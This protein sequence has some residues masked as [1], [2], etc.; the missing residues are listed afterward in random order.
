[1]FLWIFVPAAGGLSYAKI[2][3]LDA[4][5]LQAARELAAGCCKRDWGS[6]HEVPLTLS[7]PGRSGYVAAFEVPEWLRRTLDGC[8]RSVAETHGWQ[9]PHDSLLNDGQVC[10]YGPGDFFARHRDDDSLGREGWRRITMVVM[11]S[12]GFEGGAFEAGTD[13]L[14]LDAGE[15]VVFEGALEHSVLPV[16]SGLRVTLVL[17]LFWKQEN[18]CVLLDRDGVVN[19]DVGSP[20]VLRVDQLR[21]IDGVAEAIAD[22][23][24]RGHRVVVVTNQSAIRKGLLSVEGLDDI[25]AEM[26]RQGVE[27]DHV[28]YATGEDR[29]PRLKPA[30]DL[31]LRALDKTGIPSTR[32]VMIGD[33]ETD[34]QAARTARVQPLLVTSSHHGQRAAIKEEATTPTFADLPS[35]LRAVA[36]ALTVC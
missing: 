2:R 27:V 14:T 28:L 20:G 6:M 7:T 35:A 15:A 21:V 23:R 4:E 29:E 17:G 31:L 16:V 33:S 36:G 34:I 12:D 13:V 32:A 25:H 30:P 26:R 3:A 24:A 18:W 22:I 5:Y 10:V 1:M 11:L 9:R 8:V 19:R